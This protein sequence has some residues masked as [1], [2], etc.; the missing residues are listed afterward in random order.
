MSAHLVLWEKLDD[1]SLHV[2]SVG[3][4]EDHVAAAIELLGGEPD[5]GLSREVPSEGSLGGDVIAVQCVHRGSTLVQM[6]FR[7][8]GWTE[9]RFATWCDARD[10]GPT[11]EGRS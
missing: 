10:F 8:E 4:R 11:P 7:P 2:R 9:E 3:R 6:W 5:G 1:G